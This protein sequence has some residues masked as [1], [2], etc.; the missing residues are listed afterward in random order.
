[1]R[2][3]IHSRGW[4]PLLPRCGSP[5]PISTTGGGVLLCLDEAG[6]YSQASSR[7]PSVLEKLTTALVYVSVTRGPTSDSTE[8]AAAS[9]ICCPRLGLTLRARRRVYRVK[10]RLQMTLHKFGCMSLHFQ[11]GGCNCLPSQRFAF[12]LASASRSLS[13]PISNRSDFVRSAAHGNYRR[14]RVCFSSSTDGI[15]RALQC[16]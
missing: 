13:P 1:M 8:S 15:Q 9:A 6:W 5:W 12:T 11:V 16:L 14:V 10:D 7:V 2:E 3:V 4:P